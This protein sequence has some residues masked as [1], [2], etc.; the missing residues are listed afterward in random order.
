MKVVHFGKPAP[1]SWEERNRKVNLRHRLQLATSLSTCAPSGGTWGSHAECSSELSTHGAEEGSI[2]PLVPFPGGQGLLLSE[3]LAPLYFK[4]CSFV[5][6][7]CVATAG[8]PQSGK[9]ETWPT[10]EG[11]GRQTAQLVA[12]KA[13]GVKSG[14]EAGGGAQEVSSTTYHNLKQIII[15]WS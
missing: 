11:R 9:Q 13:A 6:M 15:L 14:Q 7:S 12:W 5:R 3:E 1:R 4:V 8:K 2:S 10:A